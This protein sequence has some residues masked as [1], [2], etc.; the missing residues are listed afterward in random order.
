MAQ[1]KKKPKT[2]SARQATLKVVQLLRRR[3]YQALFAGGCVRDM[4]L[5]KRP[6]DYDV[7]TNA[8]PD[9][10]TCLFPRTLTVGAQFG[11]IIV[12]QYGQ[13]IEVA[14]FRSDS[15]YCDGRHPERVVFTD[16]RHDAQRRDFTINGMFYDPFEE[17]VIDYVGGQKDLE[18]KIIRAIGNPHA[19]FT[20]D[21]L[22]MLRA[23]RFAAR[24]NFDIEPITWDAI[25]AGASRLPEISAERIVAEL[26]MMLVDP[27]RG[28]AAEM[29]FAS[30]LLNTA[31]PGMT[32][33]QLSLGKSVLAQLPERCSFALALAALLAD[34]TAKQANA[35]CRHLKCSNELR[36]QVSWLVGYRQELLNAVPMSK[37]QL[38]QWLAEPLFESLR[39][40][41]RVYIKSVSGSEAKLR[42]LSHQIKQLGDEPI[43]PPRLLNGHE[44]IQSGATPGPMVG[45]L[46]EELYLAQLE[47][48]VKTKADAQT[49]VA[50]WLI[51]HNPNKQA[52]L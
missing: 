7:A 39:Q 20:E 34:G 11:V 17:T 45:Q 40:L 41:N 19:R 15:C 32:G 49:W 12:L 36:R 46:A 10:V 16:A 31:L 1:E 29:A 2:L 42:Q 5:G 48:Q 37:G 6:H 50:Q 35:V 18:K 22:R 28:R 25:C 9:E 14:T 43:A 51:R 23:L 4:L 47:N 27:N 44:L 3:G 30:G 52:N 21:R 8:S 33:E 13:Q 38:K 26:E 24:F